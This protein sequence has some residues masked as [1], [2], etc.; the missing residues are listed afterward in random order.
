MRPLNGAGYTCAITMPLTRTIQEDEHRH[1][2]DGQDLEGL[3]F[4]LRRE[5]GNLVRPQAKSLLVRLYFRA[6]GRAATRAGQPVMRGVFEFF[7]SAS[8]FSVFFQAAMMALRIP[9]RL[10]TMAR[11]DAFSGSG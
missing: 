9:G 2:V 3:V 4:L 6:T 7:S 8:P 10:R 11:L 5:C 1:P